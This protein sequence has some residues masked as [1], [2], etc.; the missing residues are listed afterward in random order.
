M[1]GYRRAMAAQTTRLAK[2]S[3]KHRELSGLS[4]FYRCLYSDWDT[5]MTHFYDPDHQL[6]EVDSKRFSGAG[7][8]DRWI[9]RGNG[10]KD[11]NSGRPQSARAAHTTNTDNAVVRSQRRTTVSNQP[12]GRVK[13]VSEIVA[14]NATTITTRAMSEAP[15]LSPVLDAQTAYAE[16]TSEKS[17]AEDVTMTTNRRSS[18]L[19]C[20][21]VLMEGDVKPV[22]DEPVKPTLRSGHKKPT[23]HD[24]GQ[25][26]S[27]NEDVQPFAGLPVKTRRVGRAK[28]DRSTGNSS[29]ATLYGGRRRGKRDASEASADVDVK[30]DDVVTAKK[31]RGRPG[32]CGVS[33]V[34][35]KNEN[36]DIKP[37]VNSLEGKRV[38][39]AKQA[40][41][42]A[43][44]KTTG[45]K[46]TVEV[47]GEIKCIKSEEQDVKPDLSTLDVSVASTDPTVKPSD[48]VT[49]KRRRRRSRKF[50]FSNK[51]KIR[52]ASGTVERKRRKPKQSTVCADRS[53]STKNSVEVD[54]EP[55]WTRL[56]KED[57][58]PDLT[59]LEVAAAVKRGRRSKRR[60]PGSP[61]V[62]TRSMYRLKQLPAAAA[63]AADSQ[64]A[65]P[66]RCTK[67][68][69]FTF[70]SPSQIKREVES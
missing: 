11:S 32:K 17:V 22:L 62:V 8:A 60:W 52:R 28:L 45:A 23:V 27:V 38:R 14:T 50:G 3:R 39:Q 64:C 33:H 1:A 20:A 13:C 54:R 68:P 56:E 41:L 6:I 49:A 30:P 26:E 9:Q 44:G 31:R 66:A 18:R 65:S 51:G 10:R 57:V 67:S 21:Q 15:E 61:A 69:P 12:T 46:N 36:D 43:D 70:L 34:G 5:F 24:F 35:D 7:N 2:L 58:K 59:S 37:M 19:R 48:D 53:A 16:C 4:E 29:S 25:M 47:V 42:S 55:S 63:A 40:R